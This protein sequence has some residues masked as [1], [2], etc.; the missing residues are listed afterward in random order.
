MVTATRE[1]EI[2]D[3]TAEALRRHAPVRVDVL[4]AKAPQ[5]ADGILRLTAQGRTVRVPVEVKATITRAGAALLL[6]QKQRT[7]QNLLLVTTHVNPDMAE[8]LKAEGLEFIDTAGNAYINQPPLY[9]FVKGNRL[10][11]ALTGAPQKRAFKPAG[12][13]GIYAFLCNGG[14]VNEPYREIAVHAGIALGTVGWLMNDLKQEGFLLAMG[15]R[16]NRLIRKEE[17]LR[18]WV[19]AYPER[20]RPKLA[21][22]R[23]RGEQ[24]W[25]QQKTLEKGAAFWGGEIAGAILTK[26]LKPQLVTIYT[27]RLHLNALL[28]ENRLRRDTQGDVEI[29]KKFWGLGEEFAQNDRVHPILVYADLMAT[30]EQRNRE[31]AGL[32]YEQHIARLVRED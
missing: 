13:R 16:G 8:H 11:E 22:G 29:L 9:I 17:L 2:L 10:P 5:E 18:K 21:L 27:T 31:T 4:Q 3:L 28:A 30:G 24:A 12:L 6:M 20:L 25:W 23:F 26:Y 15:K 7:G 19:D 14:L 1:K 32:I